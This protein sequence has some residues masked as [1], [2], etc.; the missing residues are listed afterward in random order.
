MVS[1]EDDLTGAL[2]RRAFVNVTAAVLAERRRT[3]AAVSL[4]VM[5]VDHFKNVND[6]FGHLAG[7]DALRL[8]AGIIR[9]QLR[10]GQYVGRYAGDEFVVLLPGLD[11]TAAQALADHLRRIVLAAHIP[12]R[13]RP[14]QYM[15]VTLSIGVSTAPRHGESFEALF[16]SADRALFEA[17]RAGRDKVVV[18]G[19][20]T[21]SPPQL[22]FSRFVGRT[23]EL[24]ALVGALDESL[25]T[26][27]QVRLVIGEAGVGK[28]SLARQLLPEVRLRGAALVTGRALESESRPPYGPWAE[29]LAGLHQLGLAPAR[30]WPLLERL[31]PALGP[32]RADAPPAL[33]PQSGTAAAPGAGDV[34]AR[35][36]RGAAARDR[37]RG[38]AL[39]RRGELGCA[40]V[41]HVAAPGASGYSSRSR[42][43]A[44]RRRTASC[45]SAGSGS[46]ATSGYAS[47]VWSA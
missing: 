20:A 15:A 19:S 18:A 34:R 29:V 11:I 26:I 8:V 9:E 47:S 4:L 16:T 39:G 44:K 22:I 33:N 12:L 41:S 6:T 24:R 30:P 1:E 7:D 32:E 31:V 35:G 37:A 38:H 3:G 45:V 28:S 36:Q 14:S 5:D 25:R 27:P 23:T 10:P 2:V 42:C 13:E 43:E 40:R 46:R 21:E 17:K